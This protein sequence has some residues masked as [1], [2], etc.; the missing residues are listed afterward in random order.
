MSKY[1]MFNWFN[2]KKEEP[3]VEVPVIVAEQPKPKKP[4][5]PK[6]KKEKVVLPPK[7]EPRV[8]VLKF[9]FDPADPKLG[10]IELDWNTEFV[11][12]L[13]K[14]V[15]LGNTEEEIVDK[16]LNDVCRTIITNQFPGM[17][18]AAN[19]LAGSKIVN[20]KDLGSGKTEVS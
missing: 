1:S 18:T 4:R 20:R 10:S 3:A 12:L 7:E 9:E 19:A 8:D 16:W 6:V 11:E 13:T 2:K 17:A 5:K 15:Y 14:H